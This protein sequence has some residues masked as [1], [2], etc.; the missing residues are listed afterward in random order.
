MDTILKLLKLV[1]YIKN[2]VDEEEYGSIK[3]RLEII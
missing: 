3:K 2:I 1:Y